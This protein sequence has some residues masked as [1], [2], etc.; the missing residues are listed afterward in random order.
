MTK[1]NLPLSPDVL[2]LNP[3]L[4]GRSAKTARL[5]T[6]G[7]G[8]SVFGEPQFRSKF[9]GRAWREWAQRQGA[10]LVLYEPIT[11]NITG[12]R[13]KP[14]FVLVF[15]TGRTLIVEVKSKWDAYQSGRSS[16]HAIKQAAVEFSWIG[17]FVVLT[18]D[19]FGE[20]ETIEVKP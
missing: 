14:D 4:A 13:Y 1:L 15:R 12:G 7:V 8:A 9:E 3:E 6:G 11:L 16:K 19:K 10:Y 5:K 17:D 2:A 20:W 18:C